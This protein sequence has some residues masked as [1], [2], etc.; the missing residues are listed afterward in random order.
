MSNEYTVESVQIFS[1]INHVRARPGMYIGETDNP[2]Q[3]FSELFDNAIDEVQSGYSKCCKVYIDTSTNKYTVRDYGRGI[4]IGLKK[5]PDSTKELEVIELLCSKSFSGAKFSSDVYKLKTGLHGVGLVC[6]NALSSH[7]RCR[8]IRDGKVADLTTSQGNKISLDY[9]DINEYYSNED[10]DSHDGVLG[11]FIADPEIF[12]STEVPIEYIKTRCKVAKAFGFDNYLYIDGE[13]QELDVNSIYDLLPEESVSKYADFRVT[14]KLDNGESLE[15]AIRYTSDSNLK[16]YG[17]TNLLYNKYGGTHTRLV[18]RAIADV[19]NEFY[20]EVD[21]ELK[22]WDCVVGMRAVVAAFISYT[23]FNGQTKDKLTVHNNYF[24]DLI[25]KFKE[26]FREVLNNEP[27]L[28]LALLKRFEEYRI[29]S[30]KLSSRK[31][32]MELVKV[33]NVAKSG[34]RIKRKS[35]VN[36]LIECTANTTEGTEIYLVE[37]NSAAGTIALARDK[38]YQSVLPLRGKIK[39]ITYKSMTDALKNED[40]RKIV[41]ACGSGVGDDVDTDNCRYEKIIIACDADPDGLHITAL[42]MSVFV[43]LMPQLI[44]DGKVYVLEAPLFGYKDSDGNYKFTDIFEDI[45]EKLRTTKGFTR[46][47]GLGEMDEDEFKES[48]MIDGKR[49]LYQV[50]FPNDVDAFN[51]ILGTTSGRRELLSEVGVLINHQDIED[52]DEIEL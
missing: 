22:Y 5:V 16:L 31:E 45:P 30:N 17:F 32:I 42:V 1:D 34:G 6:C 44:K 19:W 38:K 21:T 14:S 25:D 43:S 40:V 12:D 28:R 4:P 49:K 23:E 48:C 35:V 7:Y 46:Y 39:N 29:A 51:R 24:T 33:S 3:L 27:E 26:S 52:D 13:L 37:G 10:E 41:N 15:V 36:G 47:K 18:E 8:T 11:E 2:H 50:Q 20:G 9:Y